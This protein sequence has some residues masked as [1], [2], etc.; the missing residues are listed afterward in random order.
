MSA[1]LATDALARPAARPG[2][3]LPAPAHRAPAQA[4]A[5]GHA[6]D[7]RGLAFSLLLHALLALAWLAFGNFEPQPVRR[8]SSLAVELFGMVSHR[9]VEQQQLGR[10]E[11]RAAAD[12][13]PPPAQAPQPRAPVPARPEAPKERHEKRLRSE[14][15]S[16]APSPVQ[17]SEPAREPVVP[18]TAGEPAPAAMP[19]ATGTPSS[20]LGG[21]EQ[22]LQQAV[23]M[24]EASADLIR[25]YLAGLKKA[26][27]RRLAYPAQARAEG[28]TGAPIVR[29][30]ITSAGEVLPG[31]L[32]I[33]RSSGHGALDEAAL[34]AVRASVPLEAPPRQMAVV[35]TLSFAQ[36][37]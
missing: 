30:V 11:G 20:A 23:P 28:A 34:H 12:A 19:A 33:Q 6:H 10:D 1:L 2:A 31:S 15:A 37:P 7:A 18:P 13:A 17:V 35:L 32:G 9:Q 27:Q 24:R 5:T 16:A 29:F 22:R 25:Q 3:R 21:E 26:I 36:E 14:T 4:A 8:E